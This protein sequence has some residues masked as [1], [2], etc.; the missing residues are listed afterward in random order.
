MHGARTIMLPI[1]DQTNN[2][3]TDE[4]KDSVSSAGK[5]RL[6]P[7]G[8]CKNRTDGYIIPQRRRDCLYTSL[9]CLFCCFVFWGRVKGW[10]R[11]NKRV[12]QKFTSPTACR[13]WYHELKICAAS[14]HADQSPSWNHNTSIRWV[15][16]AR[17]GSPLAL[18]EPDFLLLQPPL[19]RGIRTSTPHGLHVPVN[20]TWNRVY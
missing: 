6:E 19:P 1:E 7:Y 14:A 2:G 11:L 10:G 15:T 5:F 13:S 8:W 12:V 9:F 3:S 18:I 17:R 16:L 20:L 4:A